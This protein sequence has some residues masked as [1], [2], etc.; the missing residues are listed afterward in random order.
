MNIF[1]QIVNNLCKKIFLFQLYQTLYVQT[2][3]FPQSLPFSTFYI[4][5]PHIVII[6]GF[7][8]LKN[9]LDGSTGTDPA[10][11][12]VGNI[13]DIYEY[14]LKHLEHILNTS[15]FTDPIFFVSCTVHHQYHH[16][17]QSHHHNNHNQSINQSINHR[18]HQ[19]S[20]N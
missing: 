15:T 3:L 2:S 7:C 9:I 13:L 17:D 1:S 10:S 5:L 6:L 8:S 11:C 14:I 4:T 16:H 12:E 18:Q 20:L 19:H